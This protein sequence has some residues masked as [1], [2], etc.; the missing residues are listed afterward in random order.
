MKIHSE[1]VEKMRNYTRNECRGVYISPMN[2]P[3]SFIATVL[4]K[5]KVL[6]RNSVPKLHSKRVEKMQIY[7]RNEWRRCKTTLETGGEDANLHSKR[8]EKMQIYTRNGWRR[9]NF[10]LETSGGDCS[11]LASVGRSGQHRVRQLPARAHPPRPPA[12]PSPPGTA[13]APLSQ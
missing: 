5:G 8:V 9:C 10:T 2:I 12:A 11:N 4:F 7:T 13:L 1:R 3:T 6:Y